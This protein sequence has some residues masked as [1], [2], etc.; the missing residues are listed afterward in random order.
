MILNEDEIN[1]A[2]KDG[3]SSI[4]MRLNKYLLSSGLGDFFEVFNAF[5]S[6]SVI[7]THTLESYYGYNQSELKVNYN[8][9]LW[10]DIPV[11]L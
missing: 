7:I 11:G 4:K 10:L 5:L 6:F 3:K 8:S 2:E 1:N 9:D